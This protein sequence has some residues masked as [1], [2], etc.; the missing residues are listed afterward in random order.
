MEIDIDPQDGSRSLASEPKMLPATIKT[1]K[2][3]AKPSPRAT[4]K[5]SKKTSAPAINVTP[6]ERDFDIEANTN[7]NTEIK[8]PKTNGRVKI[9]K[10]VSTPMTGGGTI[11][12]QNGKIFENV[13]TIE[14]SLTPNS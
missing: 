12:K 7:T 14:A 4:V 13:P 8:I 9:P 3:T 2:P 6:M 1:G 5:P 10:T 11:P